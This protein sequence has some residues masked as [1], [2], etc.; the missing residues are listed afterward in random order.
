MIP[1]LL[2]SHPNV[3]YTANEKALGADIPF[4]SSLKVGIGHISYAPKRGS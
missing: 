1:S 3:Y 4:I 2:L